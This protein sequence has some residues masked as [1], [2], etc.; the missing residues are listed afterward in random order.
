MVGRREDIPHLSELGY[1][2]FTTSDRALVLESAKRWR[3]AL[4]ARP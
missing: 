4:P 3:E 2:I 1:R